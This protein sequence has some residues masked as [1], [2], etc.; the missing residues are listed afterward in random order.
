MSDA[1]TTKNLSKSRKLEARRESVGSIEEYL[2]RKRK[3]TRVEQEQAE[4][5]A[6]SSKMEE[7]KQIMISM[8]NELKNE[9]KN[10]CDQLKKTN[11][12]IKSLREEMKRREEEWR[13]ERELWSCEKKNLLDRVKKMEDKLERQEKND[14]KNN[15]II[16]GLDTEQ[17]DIKEVTQEFLSVKKKM[18]KKIISSLKD[19]ILSNAILKK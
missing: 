14:K 6:K 11:E 16:K 15:I 17:R 7:L 3:E 5:F 13:K 10:S 9:I 1:G 19:S 18:I 12:E 8:S 4:L 2:K